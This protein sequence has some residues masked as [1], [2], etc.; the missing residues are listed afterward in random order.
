MTKAVNTLLGLL[1]QFRTLW[2]AEINDFVGKLEV[3]AH[4]TGLILNEGNAVVLV[5]VSIQVLFFTGKNRHRAVQALGDP[6]QAFH[7]FREVIEHD[8]AIFRAVRQ[9]PEGF[10]TGRVV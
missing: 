7:F 1:P 8:Q 10:I 9:I 3:A 2:N 5:A 4:C 6:L